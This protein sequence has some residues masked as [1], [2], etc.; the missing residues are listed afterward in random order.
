MPEKGERNGKEF[1]FLLKAGKVS[2]RKRKWLR[3]W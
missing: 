1:M 2:E 3:Q